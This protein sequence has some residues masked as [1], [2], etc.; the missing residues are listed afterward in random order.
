[1]SDQ[2]VAKLLRSSEPLVII[3]AAAG[4]GKT[5]QGAAYAQDVVGGLGDGR[6]LILTHTH[7]ACSVFAERTKKAG[8]R[9]EIRTIDALI[10]QI[11]LAY[12]KPLGLPRDLTSWAW[13]DGGQ[14]FEIMASKVAAFLRNQPMVA[15]ALARRYP[16]IV[17]DEHQDS[18]VDQHSVVMSLLSAGATVRIFGDPMQRLYGGRSDKAAR[19]DRVRWDALKAHGAER[20]CLRLTVGK[21]AVPYWGPGSSRRGRGWSA[22]RRST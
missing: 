4:C 13:E 15:R 18:S 11:A 6:L 20:N 1:M 12:H 14:G 16:V 9:V 3:E 8:S 10:A 17:C 5:Y 22:E 19:E 7:A 21:P 2:A